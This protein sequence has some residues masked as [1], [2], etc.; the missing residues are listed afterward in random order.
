MFFKNF[1]R[2]KLSTLLCTTITTALFAT[3][4]FATSGN[5][6]LMYNFGGCEDE[7]YTPESYYTAPIV[8]DFNKD[9]KLET[10]FGNYSIIMLDSATGKILWRV[11]GGYDRTTPFVV[12]ADKI[13]VN[14]IVAQD[15]DG[16]GYDE[17]ICAQSN[18]TISVYTWDGYY[19]PGWPVQVKSSDGTTLTSNVRSLEVSD[20]DNNGKFEIIVGL[21][22]ANEESV[23]AY[24]YD[25]KM[26]P[27]WPQLSREQDG[28]K[29][30]GKNKHTGYGYGIFMN[31][32]T[33]G[34]ITGDG[35][36]EIIVP[37]DTAYISAYDT[38]GK[39]I[40]ANPTVFG[41]RTWGKIALYEDVKTE[42]NMD[43][44]EGWG[45]T[46]LTG[47]ET[48]SQTYKAEL[49]HS[50]AKVVDIDNDGKNEVVL[51]G[52]VVD[53]AQDTAPNGDYETTRYMSLFILNQDRTRY[54]GWEESPS[55]KNFMGA[56]LIQDPEA[57]N[58]LVE[59]EPVIVDLDGDGVN[60]III[61]TYDGKVHAFSVNNSKKEFGNFPYNIPQTSGVAETANPVVCV[62]INGDGKKEVIFT[63]NTRAYTKGTEPSRKGGV[64]ILNGDGTLMTYHELPDAYRIYETQKP[65]YTNGSFSAPAVVDI[66]NDGNFEVIVNT[67]YSGIATFK[68][69]A[70]K[71]DAPVPVK[72]TPTTTTPNSNN[73]P[74]IPTSS[75]IL[76]NSEDIAFDAYNIDG[77]NY[78]KLRDLAFSL[79]GTSKQF[80]VDWNAGANAISLTSNEV[81]VPQGGEITVGYKESKTASPTASKLFINNKDV[82]LTAYNIDGNNYFKL[83]D[84]GQAFDFGIDWDGEKNTIVIDTNKNYTE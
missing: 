41:G 50:I 47:K 12:G 28:S 72:E 42:T 56:P 61:N 32:V 54:K 68:I 57:L 25:G 31:G 33:S 84:I 43:F 13:K 22:R 51:T 3:S 81:Y 37:T 53:R 18:G 48:R 38:K 66:D 34:D 52:V 27:G 2:K 36:K 6:S 14:S 80:S 9:S 7:Y 10:L 75:K 16:D 64:Y 40:L 21:S 71:V 17:I 60:E 8:K 62:D 46:V 55:D 67:K 73:Q 76:I 20:L 5:L 82:S 70:E 23:W 77:N 59:A 39:L 74:A 78:F 19:K 29:N 83:R 79:S 65:A 58:S 4:A 35:I 63:T 26:M 1:S 49:G 30:I 69:N 45:P 15:I 24:T 44:N 11:N